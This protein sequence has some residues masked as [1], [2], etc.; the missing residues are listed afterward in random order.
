MALV[1][2]GIPINLDLP[3]DLPAIPFTEHR[4]RPRHVLLT[5]GEGNSRDEYLDGFYPQYSSQWDG[6]RH[7]RHPEYGFY[8]RTPEQEVDALPGRLGIEH[9]SQYGII[10]RGVL[11]DLVRFLAARGDR[12]EPDVRRALPCRLLD[13]VARNQGVEVKEGD[14]VLF[15]TG[16][17]TMVREQ[18]AGGVREDRHRAYEGPGL[19]ADEATLTWLWDQHIAAIVSDNY[20][21]EV[22]PPSPDGRYLHVEAI[23]LLGMVF[24]EL[25]DLE[26]LAEDCARDGVYEFLFMA[27]PWALPGGVGSPA[28][29]VA[30]K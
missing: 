25:F 8:N 1:Q 14:I 2:R 5:R 11:I 13:E 21:I 10:G 23:P 19:A 7:M 18:G 29:A 12:L 30:V 24:G 16:V 26:T 27:K 15:R 3:L 9:F 6:L 20:A 22:W 4:R 17:G 28:N